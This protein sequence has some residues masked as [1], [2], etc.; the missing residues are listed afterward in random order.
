VASKSAWRVL[1]FAF[2]RRFFTLEKKASSNRVEVRRVAWQEPWQEPQLASLLFDEVPNPPALLVHAE[3]VHEDELAT[4]QL[5]GQ[6][7]S[8]V[9]AQGLRV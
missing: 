3:V 5:R 7:I 2:L 9:E 1:A 4:L 8:H 6:D